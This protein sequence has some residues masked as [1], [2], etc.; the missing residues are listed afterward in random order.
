MPIDQAASPPLE[1]KALARRAAV[2]AYL[3]WLAFSLLAQLV[4]AALGA[5]DVAIFAM[6]AADWEPF[7]WELT[8]WLGYALA[9]PLVLALDAELHARGLRAPARALAYAAASL[10]FAGL[11]LLVTM[12]ARIGVY[13]LN[14]GSYRVGSLFERFAEGYPQDAVVLLILLGVALFWRRALAPA[15][16]KPLE[17]KK[18]G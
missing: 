12:A 4:N 17:T 18:G 15:E 11:H 8:S 14:G 16:T 7:A 10:P 9:A 5:R 13:E 2:A 3:A 1:P 6:D